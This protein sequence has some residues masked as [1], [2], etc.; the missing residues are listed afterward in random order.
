MRRGQR[1]CNYIQRNGLANE[2][3]HRILFN[4]SDEEFDK[5]MKIRDNIFDKELMLTL[6]D[7]DRHEDIHLEGCRYLHFK[8]INEAR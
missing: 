6:C 8:D 5:V 2:N 7:C 3:V 4:I 1:L